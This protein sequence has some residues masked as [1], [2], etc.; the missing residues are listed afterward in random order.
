MLV[1]VQ[2]CTLSLGCLLWILIY[3]YSSV[4]ELYFHLYRSAIYSLRKKEKEREKEKEKV[5]CSPINPAKHI[6]LYSDMPNQTAVP[7]Q[8]PLYP[9]DLD[10]GIYPTLPLHNP[11]TFN[12]SPMNSSKPASVTTSTAS[13]FQADPAASDAEVGQSTAL[14]SAGSSCSR[15]TS[16]TINPAGSRAASRDQLLFK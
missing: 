13:T 11:S 12:Q 16:M 6:N 15:P 2:V 7:E 9:P 14:L 1:I 8:F 4:L 10:A 5:Y 3:Q